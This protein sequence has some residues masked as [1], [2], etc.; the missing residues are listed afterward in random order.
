M[1]KVSIK[2]NIKPKTTKQ[3]QKQTQKQ[4]VNINI[5]DTITKKKRGRP[6]KKSKIEKQQIK[7]V[8]QQPIIQSYNQPIFK[9]ST[10]QQPSSLA[11]SIL[12]SQNIPSVKKEEVKE[13][14][15]IRKALIDQNLS[16]AEDPIEK[17]NDLERV[18][19]ERLKKFEKP[20][21]EIIK[22]EPIRSALLGQLLSEQGDDTEEINALKFQTPERQSFGTQTQLF[23]LSLE[24]PESFESL[25]AL[26]KEQKARSKKFDI[27]RQRRTI[28][29]TDT[30]EFVPTVN[31]EQTNETP[32]TQPEE[33]GAIDL[34]TQSESTEENPLLPTIETEINP[35]I[36]K[37]VEPID[38]TLELGFGGL[39]EGSIQTSVGTI[40]PPEPV[41]QE[42]LL[43]KQ[44]Q[45]PP[46]TILTPIPYRTERLVKDE[47]PSEGASE[48]QAEGST[49]GRAEIT[50]EAKP[51]K[52][53][54]YIR[55]K[56]RELSSA[57][58]LEGYNYTFTNKTGK[59]QVRPSKDLLLEILSIDPSYEPPDS[60][61]PGVK[62]TK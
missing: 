38:E 9:Q 23:S 49:E 7:P 50:Q 28:T 37:P 58:A 53:S 47:G 24:P 33:R 32:L 48:G 5:G 59:S 11:S 27:L 1:V 39:S 10:P 41:S 46:L 57:G 18:R 12:A 34:L 54:D 29:S 62:I 6:T 55:A 60:K 3:K 14:S 52:P 21:I 36:S 20:K 44:Q 17:T 31:E 51:L 2:K 16:T 56:W 30:E 15:T 43:R 4:I 8:S 26:R 22:D 40:L 19:V 45:L 35:F 25:S 13:E 42:Q 61:K